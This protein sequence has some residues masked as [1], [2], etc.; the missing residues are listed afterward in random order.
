MGI[1]NTKAAGAF[2]P[3]ALPSQF[4]LLNGNDTLHVEREVRRAVVRVRAGLDV[5]ERNRD[6]LAR[7]HLHVAGELSH[8]VGSHV[9]VEL[10]PYICR[11][12]RGVECDIVR[13]STYDDELYAITLLD[14][15][16]GRLEPVTLCITA[17]VVSTAT[18]VV[19]SAGFFSPPAQAPS[20]STPT[21]TV[22]P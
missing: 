4:R 5:A 8:L 14:G 2:A 18:C 6:R 21:A 16:V 10:W 15:K 7:I 3:A 19:S 12:R 9:R 17:A 22:N 1:T 13:T 11:N 20:E